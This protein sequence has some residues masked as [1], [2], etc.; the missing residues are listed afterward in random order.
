MSE[1][2][3]SQAPGAARAT[4]DRP[5]LAELSGNARPA[6]DDTG[7]THSL[8]DS[9]ILD[10]HEDSKVDES[11][12]RLRHGREQKFSST[13]ISHETKRK[14]WDGSV[15]RAILTEQNAEYG[16]I[17]D[18]R[19]T[20]FCR[21]PDLQKEAHRLKCNAH[22]LYASKQDKKNFDDFVRTNGL[23]FNPTRGE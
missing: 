1:N 22:D 12:P 6:E 23:I 15:E 19:N 14:L 10:S 13:A 9:N 4:S 8:R 7:L 5:P 18:W 21:N 20:E 2:D 16:Q 3:D 11:D 17:V